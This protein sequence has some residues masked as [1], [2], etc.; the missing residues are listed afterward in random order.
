MKMSLSLSLNPEKNAYCKMLRVIASM[1]SRIQRRDK[2][3][4]E[5]VVLYDVAVILIQTPLYL[6]SSSFFYVLA[7]L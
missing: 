4:V 5:P 3:L 2:S 1:Y 6:V 7:N